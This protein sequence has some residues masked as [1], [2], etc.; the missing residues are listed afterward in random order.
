MR[1]SMAIVMDNMKEYF[2]SIAFSQT[3]KTRKHFEKSK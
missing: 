3:L 1:W 2:N